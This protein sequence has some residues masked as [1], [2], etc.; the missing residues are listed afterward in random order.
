MR[1][2]ADQC[3]ALRESEYQYR[4]RLEAFRR[5]R[6]AAEPRTYT[7]FCGAEFIVRFPENCDWNDYE[8]GALEDAGWTL[9]G[10]EYLCPLHT[11]G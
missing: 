4:R 9:S 2:A 3:R 6:E 10:R 7:C 1:S 8:S 5:D 11:K